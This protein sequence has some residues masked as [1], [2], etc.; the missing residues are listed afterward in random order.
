VDRA[1]LAYLL[2]RAVTLPPHRAVAKA[3]GFARRRALAAWQRRKDFIHGSYSPLRHGLPGRRRLSVGAADIAPDLHEP[4]RLL[5]DGHRRHRFNLLGSGWVEV[6]YGTACEGFAGRAFPPRPAVVADRDGAWLAQQVNASNLA[7]AQALWRRIDDPAY[8][9]IDWQLDFRSGYRWRAD[10]HFSEL[11]IPVDT[12]A[13]IKVPWEL[14][15]LQHLPQLA[16]CA[17]LAG[18]GAAGFAPAAEYVRE[19]R[20]QL[21]DFL[22]LNPPRFGVNWMCPMDVGIRVANILLAMNFLI[23]AGLD[24]EQNLIDQD[25][26]DIVLRCVR[27]H[28]DHIADHLEWSERGRSNHYLA[29]L[30]GLLWAAS[31]LAP[32]RRTDAMF[33]FAAAELL[34]EGDRQFGADGGNYEGSTN[35]HRL[36]SELVLFGTALLSGLSE[37]D[38]ARLDNAR[39][40]ALQLRAPWRAAPL[41]RYPLPQGNMTVVP[42]VLR[43]KLFRAGELARAATRPDGR[44]IQV[45][46]T[47]SGRLFKLAPVGWSEETAAG[48]AFEEDTLDH[49]TMVAGIGALFGIA[50]D[51]ETIDSV[52]VRR[53][54]GLRT[55]PLP[56]VREIED[57]GDLDAVIE[58]IKALPADCRHRRHIEFAERVRLDAWRR[59]AFPDFGLYTLAADRAFIAFRCA[60]PPPPEAPLGHTHDDNLA[61]EYVLGDERRIDPGTLCY[62]PS[63]AWRNRYRSAEA[64]DV[65]RAIDWDVAPAGSALFALKH[66]AWAQC[67]AWRPAGIAGEIAVRRGRLLR[68]LKLTE[69]GFDIWD[70]VHPPDRLRPIAP[71][72]EVAVGYGQIEPARHRTP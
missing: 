8:Q 54:A 33:A 13:D 53:L 63:R 15:R 50:D 20:C 17:M 58:S 11:A 9:P 27:D 24:S 68:A 70:G 71:Q 66:A 19:L 26:M 72:I 34:L 10:A 42:P 45:G 55:F 48:P 1:S 7:A 14:G 69:T 36:S 35:Y 32:D 2:R 62:T 60:P 29:N 28:A 25:L 46:D 30:V 44:V 18:S 59:T 41:P 23:G 6:R 52:V 40:D 64:H 37:D 49:R 61:I 4:L 3:A 31:H 51:A 22:A 16:L 57:H 43:E 12:G 65:V 67:L 39:A 47:D 5:G 21:L 38:L 56:A